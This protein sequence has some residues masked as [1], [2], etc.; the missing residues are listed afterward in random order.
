MAASCV[1]LMLSRSDSLTFGGRWNS[2]SGIKI[3]INCWSVFRLRTVRSRGLC[4]L[5]E[6]CHE[7]A[8]CKSD[9]VNIVP[10]LK[11]IS[12][13]AK[14]SV[15][16]VFSLVD[17]SL[18]E[19]VP[20]SGLHCTFVTLFTQHTLWYLIPEP[21]SSLVS[22]DVPSFT[23]E[24]VVSRIAVRKDWVTE[25]LETVKRLSRATHCRHERSTYLC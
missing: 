20:G 9:I 4:L 25:G 24:P 5:Q 17:A 18:F 7:Y 19:V 22:K 6:Y 12:V 16:A 8:A 11:L 13:I 10:S 1:F 3:W 23:G 2:T 14:N 21:C 15:W